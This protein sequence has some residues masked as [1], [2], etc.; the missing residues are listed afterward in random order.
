MPSDREASEGDDPAAQHRHPQIAAA[1][2][3]YRSRR[4]REIGRIARRYR[5]SV[6]CRIRGAGVSN[7]AYLRH[8]DASPRIALAAWV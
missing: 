8:D 2:N 4:R 6:V 5:R 7:I 1:S 3:E